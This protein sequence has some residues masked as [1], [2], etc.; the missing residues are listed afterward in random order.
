MGR[1]A[2][3]NFYF[4]TSWGEDGGADSMPLHVANQPH[5]SLSRSCVTNHASLTITSLRRPT[6]NHLSRPRRPSAA[7]APT[8]PHHISEINAALKLKFGTLV[9]IYEY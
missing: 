8:G 4:G 9:V 6:V 2:A 5:Q 1:S 7:V 3:I